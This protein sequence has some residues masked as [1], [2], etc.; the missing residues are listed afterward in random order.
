MKDCK[1]KNGCKHCKP[2]QLWLDG[3]YTKILKAF[4]D[5][6]GLQ[7]TIEWSNTNF[8]LGLEVSVWVKNKYMESTLNVF[9][10]GRIAYV[11]NMREYTQCATPTTIEDFSKKI[12]DGMCGKNLYLK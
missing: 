4:A 9:K 11:S 2:E 6:N 8:G 1:E 12:V 10:Y 5:A 7:H 3:K